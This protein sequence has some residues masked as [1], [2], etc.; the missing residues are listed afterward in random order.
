MFGVYPGALSSATNSIS[1]GSTGLTA[2]FSTP[3]SNARTNTATTTVGNYLPIFPY[4]LPS[5]PINLQLKATPSEYVI[6][7]GTPS[8]EPI[9]P[10][11]RMARPDNDYGYDGHFGI[12]CDGLVAT[13]ITFFDASMY[14]KNNLSR[15]NNQPIILATTI[16][17]FAA[18][19]SG[20]AVINF[21]KLDGPTACTI[22]SIEVNNQTN[23]TLEVYVVR[24][25]YIQNSTLAL[26]TAIGPT[27]TIMYD[28][29]YSSDIVTIN[30]VMDTIF[31]NHVSTVENADVNVSVSTMCLYSVIIAVDPIKQVNSGSAAVQI[32][33][34]ECY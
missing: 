8:G 3:I 22:K 33:L 31:F 32:I 6:A 25:A 4:T 16:N 24:N 1:A 11:H 12:Y 20:Y 21:L 14:K 7:L 27:N 23:G 26:S 2:T 15:S 30:G 5:G 9:T 28:A 10:I 34:E 29:T 18:F 19:G 13:N 17:T